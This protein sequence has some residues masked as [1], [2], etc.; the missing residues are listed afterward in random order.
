MAA[1]TGW[2]A[3]GWEPV[4]DAF[5]L[6]FDKRHEVGAAFSAYHRGEKVVDL[7]GGVADETTGRP[8]EE[9]TIVV[10]FSTTKGATALCANLLAQRGE[11]DVDAPVA[12]YWPEF[13][14]NGKEH[15]TVDHLLSHRAGLAWV[16][17]TMTLEEVIAWDPVIRA[18]ERQAPIWEPGTK[19]GYHATT[20]GWLVGE[21]VRRI[22]G[23]SVGTFF[24][25]EVAGPLGLD[26]HIGLAPS[27][28]GRVA[29]LISI[30]NAIETGRID[31][32]TGGGDGSSEGDNTAEGESESAYLKALADRAV[33][34]LAPEGPLT[35]ALTAPG[36]ALGGGIDDNDTRLYEAEMPAFNGIGDARSIARMYSSCINEVATDSGEKIRLLSEEQLAQAVRQRTEGPDEVLLGL[37]IHWGLGF[38]INKGIIGEATPSGPRAFGHFGMGGSVGWGD[39]DAELAASY[40][41]N[42]MDI[43]TTGDHRA[44]S[45]VQ[46][47]YDVLNG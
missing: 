26:F 17:G 21:V 6:N 32:G 42:R 30:L 11:L 33:S 1:P 16:D 23:K 44:F 18:L 37:D 40:V 22:S 38:M 29:K 31:F 12:T 43:G 2:T 28:H 27:E 3:P 4:A 14:A 24:R 15:V 34:Y 35:K 45:L 41:M 19:H 47:C 5:R 8:W 20:Y 46:A 13:A 25:D 10:V 7:W 36:G 9:D 39:P